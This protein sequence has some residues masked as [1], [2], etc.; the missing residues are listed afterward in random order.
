[1]W[2]E[3]KN[4]N[5]EYY[6]I[7]VYIFGQQ[8]ERRTETIKWIIDEQFSPSDLLELERLNFTIDNGKLMKLSVD[9]I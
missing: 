1:M 9:R 4:Q 6:S 5:S 3:Y 8:K 2:F 7:T